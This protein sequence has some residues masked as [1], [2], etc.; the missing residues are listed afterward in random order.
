MIGW[1]GQTITS[2]RLDP[3][4]DVSA[5]N[6]YVDSV[7]L[8]K[9]VEGRGAFDLAFR[10]TAGLPGQSATV[11]LDTNRTGAD[12]V[13]AATTAVAAGTNRVRVAMPASLAG[14]TYW[15]YV[16]VDGPSGRVVRYATSPVRLTR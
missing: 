13:Q 12:G 5:R 14:G 2:L 15:P 6:W 16:V 1:A 4:E 11:Y 7:R 3:N 9:D 8:A 10:E